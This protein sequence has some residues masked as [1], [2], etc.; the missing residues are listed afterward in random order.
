M[1]WAETDTSE[2]GYR[3]RMYA[4]K[5]SYLAGENPLCSLS[6]KDGI[7]FVTQLIGWSTEMQLTETHRLDAQH[8]ADVITRARL[9]CLADM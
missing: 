1:Y 2:K 8:K 7:W 6:L 5:D 3:W 4:D 9:R